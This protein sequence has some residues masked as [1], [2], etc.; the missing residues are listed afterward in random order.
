MAVSWNVWFWLFV[1]L[2]IISFCI[3]IVSG[4]F[5]VCSQQDGERL[6]GRSPC[7][8]CFCCS[9]S[10][11]I[12]EQQQALANEYNQGPSIPQSPQKSTTIARAKSLL[13]NCKFVKYSSKKLASKFGASKKWKDEVCPICLEMYKNG[14][15]IAVCPC[16]HGYHLLCLES[17]LRV[18]NDCPLCK[19]IVRNEF[20]ERSPLL[21]DVV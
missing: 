13:P 17:W 6:E 5:C 7:L 14:E 4:F 10:V 21:F 19:R 20:S 18:K 11:Q 3:C 1:G 12:D 16:K 9:H 15:C 2:L 8:M